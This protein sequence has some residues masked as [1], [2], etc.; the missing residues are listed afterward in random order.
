VLDGVSAA[1]GVAVL[2]H[3]SRKKAWTLFEP[4]WVDH[5]L[6]IEAWNRK[7]D[8]WAP[9]D[10]APALLN[11]SG[12]IPFVGLDFHTHR[13]SFPLRMALEVPST[14]VA[15][16][17]VLASLRSR[18]CSPRAFGLP[19]NHNFIRKASAVLSVAEQSRRTV[20]LIARRSGV[21]TE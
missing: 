19:F 20:A 7:Y 18:R 11:A 4:R 5:L 12:A 3:P 9:S 14:V 17:T 16:E 21:F 13:Q 6:G 15:E 2:A 10:R 8:G 1:K